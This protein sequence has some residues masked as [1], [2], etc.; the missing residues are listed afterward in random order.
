MRTFLKDQPLAAGMDDATLCMMIND[1]GACAQ[2]SPL[3]TE[4]GLTASE[5]KISQISYFFVF[6]NKN[7]F[8][9]SD[10]CDNK[11]CEAGTGDCLMLGTITTAAL[12]ESVS[13][14][15]HEINSVMFSQLKQTKWAKSA[16]TPRGTPTSPL[17][18]QR[19]SWCCP[20]LWACSWRCTRRVASMATAAFRSTELS[21]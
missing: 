4:E 13:V 3:W 11:C 12:F 21:K 5:W 18:R 8:A 17:W 2:I 14:T 10:D 6:L 15:T 7:I 1:G 16:W 19:P 9:F 20:P